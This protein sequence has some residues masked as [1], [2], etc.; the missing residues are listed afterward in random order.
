MHYGFK[1]YFFF[2]LNILLCVS[3]VSCLAPARRADDG[4]VAV[5]HAVLAVVVVVNC[6]GVGPTE[7]DAVDDRADDNE[8]NDDDDKYT[9]KK[10]NT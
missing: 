3:T 5:H 10:R 4:C 2:R 1:P 6:E 9:V 8:E 7:E